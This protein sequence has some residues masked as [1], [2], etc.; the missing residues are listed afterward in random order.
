MNILVMPDSIVVFCVKGP[1]ATRLVHLVCTQEL[2]D[3]V[4]FISIPES[5]RVARS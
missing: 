2:G 4:L 5:S 3:W 1:G